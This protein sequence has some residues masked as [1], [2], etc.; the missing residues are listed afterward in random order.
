MA[1]PEIDIIGTGNLATNLA[2]SLE[3]GGFVVNNVYGRN[4]LAAEKLAG[5]LYQAEA[6]C[7]S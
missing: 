6:R 1:L 4:Y 3:Q 2:P 5:R 7:G